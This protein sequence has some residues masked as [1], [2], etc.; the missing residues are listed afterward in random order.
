MG[1]QTS[2]ARAHQCPTSLEENPIEK[3]SKP[4]RAGQG[5]IG[6]LASGI[7]KIFQ[8]THG[9]GIWS[10]KETMQPAGAWMSK[11]Q[12]QETSGTWG[13]ADWF[14]KPTLLPPRI[15]SACRVKS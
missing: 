4:L 1:I 10:S 14:L 5:L 8:K 11:R 2:E 15:I 12:N 6:T 13:K 9:A 3:E 7:Q